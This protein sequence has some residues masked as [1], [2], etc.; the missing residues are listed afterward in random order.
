MCPG[1]G[2]SIH[3]LMKLQSSVFDFSEKYQFAKI[4]ILE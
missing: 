1:H 3:E 4:K 2:L